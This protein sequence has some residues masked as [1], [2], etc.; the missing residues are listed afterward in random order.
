M[1]GAE[2]ADTGAELGAAERD[3][4]LPNVRC[5]NVA[6]LRSRVGENVLNEIIAVLVTGDVDERNARSVDSALADTVK[7]ATKKLRATN[8]QALLNNLGGKLVH[9]ILGSIA[10]D[11]IDSA[12][13]V[14]RGAMLADMLDAPVAKLAMSHNVDVGQD[15]FDAGTLGSN[16]STMRS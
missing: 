10:D 11:M 12:A 3:H 5:D 8:L 6:V 14:R 16:V 13:P 2:H 4:V 1:V 9:A 15:F 7:V